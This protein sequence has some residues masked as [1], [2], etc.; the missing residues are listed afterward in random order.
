[1][2]EIIKHP[3]FCTVLQE[4]VCRVLAGENLGLLVDTNMNTSKKCAHEANEANGILGCIKSAA[5]MLREVICT[6]C[7][8]LNRLHLEH[9]EQFWTPQY[10]RDMPIL[11]RD[12]HRATKLIKELEHLSWEDR[13]REQGLFSLQKAQGL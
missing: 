9:C 6:V 7:S 1:M 11:E 4:R 13:L 2:P 8:A 10:E 5:G 12:Q 3:V